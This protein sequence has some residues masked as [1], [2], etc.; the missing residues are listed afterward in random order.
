MLRLLFDFVVDRQAGSVATI[1]R[2]LQARVESRSDFAAPRPQ[3][4]KL[5]R[6]PKEAQGGTGKAEDAKLPG[7]G[8]IPKPCP[9]VAWTVEIIPFLNSTN[10]LTRQ[11]AFE[12]LA[13][14]GFRRDE[15]DGPAAR[16]RNP[17]VIAAATRWVW[18]KDKIRGRKMAMDFLSS[19]P[20]YLLLQMIDV[21]ST[22][23]RQKLVRYAREGAPPLI[24]NA[25]R[26]L[27]S[28]PP[29]SDLDEVLNSTDLELQDAAYRCMPFRLIQCL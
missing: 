8:I 15:P 6:D 7:A 12:A 19:L 28:R 2:L 4:P 17:L 3:R 14:L 23:E 1:P 10:Y 26:V 22:A 27:A 24:R 29:D 11:A 21:P 5:G 18:Q 25:A 13:D 20:Q 9:N 16:E